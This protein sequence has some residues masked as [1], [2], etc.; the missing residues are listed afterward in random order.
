MVPFL[1]YPIV[2]HQ[3]KTSK[4]FII[5]TPTEL[6]NVERSVFMTDVTTQNLWTFQIG[7]QKG[8]NVVI[9]IIIGFQQ[10]EG[11]DSQNLNNHLFYRT[12]I[13]SA[14][15][16]FGIDNYTDSAILLK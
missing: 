3:R 15:C 5:E 6:K 1:F 2:F 13:T 14:Q 11:Q 9:W 16:V 4:Q 12:P 8:K 7:T 10:K